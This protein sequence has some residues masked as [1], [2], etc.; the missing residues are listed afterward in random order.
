MLLCT[1][2]LLAVHASIEAVLAS[3]VAR[4]HP[5]LARSGLRTKLPPL[6]ADFLLLVALAAPLQIHTYVKF[7]L[8]FVLLAD[9]PPATVCLPC[10]S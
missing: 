9:P 3:H 7:Y 5:P 8:R 2:H 6:P 10:S 4:A 1:Q